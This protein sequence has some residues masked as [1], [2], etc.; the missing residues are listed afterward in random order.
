VKKR[1]GYP[2]R[3]TD[4]L[5]HLD[6]ALSAPIGSKARERHLN[7]ALLVYSFGITCEDQFG[8]RGDRRHGHK[9]HDD[10]N[11]KNIMDEIWR[12]TG[13]ERP[14]AVARLAVESGQVGL[15]NAEP[16]SVIRRLARNW[17]PPTD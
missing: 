17:R 15:A 11:A 12:V 5:R 2:I 6:R 13:E 16:E 3:T 8:E 1:K 14:F 10:R 4:S 9:R 7:N